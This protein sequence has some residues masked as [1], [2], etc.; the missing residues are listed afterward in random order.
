I[1][2]ALDEEYLKVD[3]QYGGLDQRKILMFARKY[4]PK[5]NYKRRIEI[6]TPMIPALTAGAKMS[7][8]IKTSK[9]DLIDS[10]SEIKTKI[11][12][13]FCPEGVVEEN[14]ILAFVKYII[15]VI[16]HD[17]NGEFVIE[18]SEKFG[19]NIGYKAY[20][21]LEKDFVGKKIHP[22]DLKRAVAREIKI[23]LKPIR[24]KI[25]TKNMLIKQAYP[26]E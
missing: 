10:E 22:Q 17:N 19:G 1:M 13:A 12:N 6:M 4:L 11:N 5:M 24:K 21:S 14:G 25:K 18:R 23:L 9:I 7:A 15:M 8:S 2:Q 26:E 16:K 3:I 20:D